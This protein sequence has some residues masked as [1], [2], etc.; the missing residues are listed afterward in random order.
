MAR[1]EELPMA[2]EAMEEDTTKEAASAADTV[3]DTGADMVEECLS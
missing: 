1:G 2:K 3:A